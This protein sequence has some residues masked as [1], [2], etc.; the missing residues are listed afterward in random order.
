LLI[1]A[2]TL[3]N[4][5]KIP[6]IIKREY[7]T[8]VRKRSFLVMTFLTPLLLAG[9]WIIPMWLA[10][11][12]D[13]KEKTLAVIDYTG[14][15]ENKIED[16]K[17]IKFQFIPQN[18][19]LELRSN[20]KTSDYY[21]FLIISEDL[22]K[23]P[24]AIKLYSETTITMDVKDHVT[25]S[26]KEYLK[27]EKLRSYNIENFN[28]IMAEIDNINV[29]VAIVKVSDDGTEKRSSSEVAMIISMV[30]GMLSYMFVLM[31]GTQVFNGV[32]QE[33][34]SRIVEVLISS[35]KPFELMMG[36]IVGIAMVA[37]TQFLLWII[38]TVVIFFA[39]TPFFTPSVDLTQI[40]PN[41]MKNM[42]EM[43]SVSGFQL[44]K[45]VE[46]IKSFNP[47]MTLLLFA[48]YFIGGYL[49]YASLYAAVASAVDNEADSQQF[50]MPITLPIILGFFIAFT[51][52]NNPESQVVF[53]G[54]MIPFTSPF[55]MMA[56]ITYGVPGWEIFLSMGLLILGFVF[57][58]WFAARIYRT[59]ILMYGKK[60][61]YK[62][63]W[64]WFMYSG[65]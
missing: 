57:T 52:F 19:E 65:K 30:F 5:K 4:M 40:D 59:G 35:V 42:E 27:E 31:Y 32:M 3:N 39:V 12:K 22:M 38:L 9:V 45:I 44:D 17:L 20:F 62:E 43:M 60:V 50:M 24:G 64:K 26:L 55:V 11:M 46:I 10:T 2:K 23:N 18:E 25:R 37:F 61:D 21:A 49:L 28:E 14:L 58:T 36:K 6:L 47:V 54:S 34:T 51:T 53:W 7:L 16:A 29:D 8:R 13:D 48:F 41:S 33:K 56:R 15:Y 1:K 63:L